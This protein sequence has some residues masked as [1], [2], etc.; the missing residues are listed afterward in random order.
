MFEYE[1]TNDFVAA[2]KEVDILLDFAGANE[3]DVDAIN[4]F[5]K[6][7]ILLL[8]AKLEAFMEQIV[9]DYCY[10]LA[11]LK[12]RSE[13][14]PYDVRAYA[15]TNYLKENVLLDLQSGNGDKIAST[16]QAL[17]ELWVEG[18][19]PAK[20]DVNCSFSYGKHGEKEI[21]RLFQRIGI[22]DVFETCKV[23]DTSEELDDT[24]EKT[25]V[26][27]SPT[28]NALIGYRNYIIH[29]DG[30][31]SV[32]H[33]QIR[34]YRD[35]ILAFV[36]QVDVELANKQHDLGETATLSAPKVNSER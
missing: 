3:K 20:V 4:A 2:L 25:P 6:A 24:V 34:K 12:L 35:L 17:G 8:T 26:S 16:M 7:A 27:V 28:M 31:P 19:V 18:C 9:E 13:C 36:K 30:T 33:G 14:I 32:T 1:A 15:S 11:S 22:P 29:N 23:P 5:N 21:R 10:K